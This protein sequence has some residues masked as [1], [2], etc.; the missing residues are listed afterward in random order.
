L[1]DQ[2]PILRSWVT[3]NAR[4]VKMYNAASSLVC[5]ENENIFFHFEKRSNAGM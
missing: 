5:F 1:R 3:Y 2:E 4:A